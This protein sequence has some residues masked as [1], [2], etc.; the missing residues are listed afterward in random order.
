MTSA[1][2]LE[3]KRAMVVFRR[4]VASGA[5]SVEAVLPSGKS[6]VENR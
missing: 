1:G 2:L 5:I 4:N 6:F 3:T